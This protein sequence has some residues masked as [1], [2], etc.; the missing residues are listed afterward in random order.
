VTPSDAGDG[1][2]VRAQGDA[3]ARSPL[4]SPRSLIVDTGFRALPTPIDSYD[5]DDFD[6]PTIDFIDGALTPDTLVPD[7]CRASEQV[8]RPDEKI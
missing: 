3:P 4:F 2:E 8:L 5:L 6:G 7:R 1:E